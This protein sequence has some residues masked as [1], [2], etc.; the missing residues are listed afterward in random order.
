MKKFIFIVLSMFLYQQ[1][2][3]SNIGHVKACNYT[4]ANYLK[5]IYSSSN[6]ATN[7]R[8]EI[9]NAVS[10]SCKKIGKNEIYK[11]DGS[12]IKSTLATRLNEILSLASNGQCLHG[13]IVGKAMEY[14]RVLDS[15]TNANTMSSSG[16]GTG[17]GGLEVNSG[18]T[19]QLIPNVY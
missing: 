6:D 18:N 7:V 17:T 4:E 19:T 12:N 3:A 2:H 5:V 11:V 16:T 10:T 8:I 9:C 1:G 14:A 13:D 15:E